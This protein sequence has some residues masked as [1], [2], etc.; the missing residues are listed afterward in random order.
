MLENEK[1][2]QEEIEAARERLRQVL[3]I[4]K[5]EDI[6]CFN[7]AVCKDFLQAPPETKASRK[8]KSKSVD[9]QKEYTEDNK[10]FDKKMHEH[11]DWF[12]YQEIED[13]NIF[14]MKTYPKAVLICKTIE[15]S[16][17]ETNYNNSMMPVDLVKNNTYTILFYIH[18]MDKTE[19]D[20]L[21]KSSE[22]DLD[23]D[24]IGCPMYKVRD[25]DHACR[26]I[27]GIGG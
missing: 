15:I 20:D 3:G 14:I 27:D 2:Q 21:V 9:K 19:V 16:L 25:F 5:E 8:A 12:V 17:T 10:E 1:R 4:P 6:E 18:W 11:I 22:L 7:E 23:L 13:D 24:V 26:V